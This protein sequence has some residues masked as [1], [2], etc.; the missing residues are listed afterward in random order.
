MN[1]ALPGKASVWLLPLSTVALAMVASSRWVSPFIQ[2]QPLVELLPW[3]IAGIGMM[4]G[5]WF[6][7]S[8]VVLSLGLVLI[9]HAILTNWFATPPRALAF[10]EILFGSLCLLLPLNLTALALLPERGL[11]GTAG[12]NR[13]ALILSQMVIVAFASGDGFGLIG[14]STLRNLQDGLMGFYN[15]GPFSGLFTP[16]AMPGTAK[17]AFLFCIVL[18]TIK[19]IRSRSPLDG[20]TLGALIAGWAT[21]NTVGEGTPPVAYLTAMALVLGLGLAQTIYGMA[22]LDDL[23]GLPARR[24]LVQAMDGLGAKFT[25]AMVD[26]D[27]FKKFNDTYGHDVGDQV[28]KMVASRLRGV[29]GGAKAYRYGGE[30]FSVLFPGKL[31]EQAEPHLEELRRQIEQSS[32]ALRH[33][34]RPDQRPDGPVKR[35]RE[36]EKVNVTVSIGYAGRISKGLDAE[37]IMKSADEAL[38]RAKDGGRNQVCD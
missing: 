4:V 22:F 17:M 29:T 38:Y 2:A 9:T 19:T 24:A 30:E 1:N 31:P 27:H 14:P 34:D 25:I 33:K 26:V 11:L 37:E 5:V 20:A 15:E 36:P 10:D 16:T 12:L 28:L 8:R 23:T 7:R 21:F 3:L 18:M 6:K 13:I 35:N 32:F